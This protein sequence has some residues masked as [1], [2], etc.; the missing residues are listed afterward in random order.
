MLSRQTQSLPGLALKVLAFFP[1]AL[2][3]YFLKPLKKRADLNY[4][5]SEDLPK[6]FFFL[7]INFL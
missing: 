6:R 2:P 4:Q 1:Y 5:P 7:L 3:I